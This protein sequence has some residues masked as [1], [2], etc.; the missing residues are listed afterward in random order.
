MPL[1]IF[2]AVLAVVLYAFW[3]YH[4]YLI[5]QNT[6]TNEVYKWKQVKYNLDHWKAEKEKKEKEEKED[7]GKATKTKKK[8]QDK[9]EIDFKLAQMERDMKNKYNQGILKNF[10]EVMY[11]PCSRNKQIKSQ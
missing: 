8:E 7:K 3:L 10:W 6:T 1:G 2:T 4:I 11:P 5:I 9:R